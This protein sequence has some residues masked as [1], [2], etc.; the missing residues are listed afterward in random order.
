[1]PNA[2][3]GLNTVARS[4]RL[5]PGDEILTTDHEYGAL[6]LTWQ[7]HRRERGIQVVHRELPL[8]ITDESAVVEAIWSGVTP[9][10]KIIF[11]SHI[12]SPTVDFACTGDLS[13]GAK[14]AY[15]HY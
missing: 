10:T 2:T 4:L 7:Y 11:M 8:P 13:A 1:V 9:R 14:L 3:T 15:D 5:K 6:E 12:T